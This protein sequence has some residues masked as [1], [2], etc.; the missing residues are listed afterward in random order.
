MNVHTVYDFDQ[1]TD[2]Y[3]DLLCILDDDICIFRCLH[4]KDSACDTFV[5]KL[6]LL[7]NNKD[8]FVTI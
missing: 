3:Y 7:S 8:C 4:F 2:L 5:H 1:F 6:S